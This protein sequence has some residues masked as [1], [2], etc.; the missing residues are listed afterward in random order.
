MIFKLQFQ[1][2]IFF[3]LQLSY[4]YFFSYYYSY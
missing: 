4:S 1:L 2:L 3:V